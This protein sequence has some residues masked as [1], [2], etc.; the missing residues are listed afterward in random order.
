M[1]ASYMSTIDRQLFRDT[2][3][4][5]FRSAWHTLRQAHPT[6]HFYS[7]GLYTAPC[8]E[9]LVVTASTE[10]GLAA[11]TEKYLANKGGDPILTRA[12]LRW[13]PC[14]SPIHEE[15][16][17]LLPKSERLRTSG[18]DPYEGTAEVEEAI[19][20]VLEATVEVLKQLDNENTFGNDLERSKLVLG[21][22]MGDQSDED[23]V[24][25]VSLLNPPSIVR[26]FSS[27]LDEGYDAF[28]QLSPYK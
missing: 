5:E 23:R 28:T 21:I 18:P 2:L 25:F 20:L 4:A 7:F 22:W 24:E 27:E 14:D 16:E 11:V 13:S 10:E 17:S 12:S 1:L 8:A 26:R 15:G 9:Y 19:A 6:E 3:L